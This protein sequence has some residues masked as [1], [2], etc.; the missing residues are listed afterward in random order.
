MTMAE[1]KSSVQ[2][3]ELVE[4]FGAGTAAVISPVDRIDYLGEDIEIP[5]DDDGM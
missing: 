1:I 4:L 5:V 3:G 2:K